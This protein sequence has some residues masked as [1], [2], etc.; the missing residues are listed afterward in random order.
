MSTDNRM[1]FIYA[2]V[3]PRDSAIRYVGQALKPKRRLK[4]HI[5]SARKQNSKNPHKDGWIR[6]LLELGLCP[7]LEILEFCCIEDSPERER[8]WIKKLGNGGSPLTNITEGG[9][10]FGRGEDSIWFGVR[11]EAHPTYG[12]RRFGPDNP[13]WGHVQS[14]E[15]KRLIGNRVRK[16]YSDVTRTPWYGKHLTQEHRDKISKSHQG[17]KLPKSECE[18]R[19]E[20]FSGQGNP[21]YGRKHSETAKAKMKIAFALYIADKHHDTDLILELQKSYFELYGYFHPKYPNEVQP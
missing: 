2:L 1:V 20:I 14:D 9:G 10:G 3:D 12:L 6:Q 19:S 8:L 17:R 21:M 18:R 16:T 5:Q 13:M 4:E 11:G 15:T 7:E